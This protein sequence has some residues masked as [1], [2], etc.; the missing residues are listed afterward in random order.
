MPL[1]KDRKQELI[2]STKVVILFMLVIAAALFIIDLLFSYLFTKI[3][4]LRGAHP[5][6]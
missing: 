2:G 6:G 5:L 3:G 4:V 1:T